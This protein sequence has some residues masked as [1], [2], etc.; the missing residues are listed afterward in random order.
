L[1][2]AQL[3]TALLSAGESSDHP[4]AGSRPAEQVIAGRP[5][6]TPL[7]QTLRSTETTLPSTVASSPLMGE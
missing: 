2:A 6:M 1:P 4:L 7:A 3:S 5:T